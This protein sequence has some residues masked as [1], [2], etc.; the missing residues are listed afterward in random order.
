MAFIDI[1]RSRRSTRSF[2]PEPLPEEVRGL[3]IEAGSLA[4]S[5]RNLRPVRLTP[6]TDPAKVRALAGCKDSGTAALETATFAVVVS[7]DP[8]DS[9]TWIQDCSIAAVMM[10][11]EAEDLG[12]GSCWIHCLDRSA[13]GVPSDEIVGGIAG[14]EK[15]QKVLCVVAFGARA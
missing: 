13:K 2:T 11:L 5:G 1:A 4:P 7:A 12:A 10:Q 3:I 9:P 15:G 8:G 6:V 14:L